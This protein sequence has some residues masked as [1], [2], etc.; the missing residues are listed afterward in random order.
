MFKGS[1]YLCKLL[2]EYGCIIYIIIQSTLPPSGSVT[3]SMSTILPVAG[4][5]YLN[6]V[7]SISL[8]SI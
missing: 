1:K 2:Y 7:T 5:Q 4:Q 3:H 8:S 6:Y